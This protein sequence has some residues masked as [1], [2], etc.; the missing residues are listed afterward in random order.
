MRVQSGLFVL[1]TLCGLPLPCSGSSSADTNK[2]FYP[3]S[4]ISPYSVFTAAPESELDSLGI[5]LSYVGPLQATKRTVVFGPIDGRKPR[6]SDFE[7][8]HLLDLY[9]PDAEVVTVDRMALSTLIDSLGTLGLRPKVP[10]HYWELLVSMELTIDG[11]DH[12]FETV[13]DSSTSTIVFRQFWDILSDNHAAKEALHAIGC[14][15]FLLPET[16]PMD[17]T[18]SVNVDVGHVHVDRSS[19]FYVAMARIENTSRED[20]P[21]PMIIAVDVDL[22]MLIKKSDGRA[23]V[24]PNGNWIIRLSDEDLAPGQH[25]TVPLYFWGGEKEGIKPRIWVYS[26]PGIW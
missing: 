13:L 20:L 21:G 17:V 14:S 1:V 22:P 6:V 26:G 18:N 24:I 4:P 15:S 23:C 12:G 2:A 5:L 11:V 8:Y 19:G 9:I 3:H 25:V 10:A 16:P 7:P